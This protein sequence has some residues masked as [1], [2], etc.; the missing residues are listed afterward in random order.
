M[1]MERRLRAQLTASVAA[2][3]FVMLAFIIV[4]STFL[5]RQQLDA[6]ADAVLDIVLDYDGSV[7]SGYV[8][9]PSTGSASINDI[10]GAQFFVASIDPSGSVTGVNLDGIGLLDGDTALRLAQE[11][12]RRAGPDSG[13]IEGYRY[14][15]RHGSDG[16]MTVAFL[17]RTSQSDT[18]RYSTLAIS[19][20]SLAVM[21]GTT[22]VFA[23]LS[24]RIVAPIVRS[25]V[26]QRQFVVD[27]G[28]DLRTPVSIISADADILA[29]DIGEDNEWLLDIKRQVAVMSELT[30]SLIVLSRA[31]A[32]IA[33]DDVVDIGELVGEQVSSFRSRALLEGHELELGR[34][35]GVW[36]RGNRQY[37]ARMVGSLLDNALKYSSVGAAI[38]VRVERHVRQ[39][40]VS[41]SNAVDDADPADVRRWFDRFYQSDRSRDHHVG[42]FGIGLAMVRAVAEAHGGRA[43][44]SVSSDHRRV[45]MTV[46]MPL[47]VR[48]GNRP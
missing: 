30:E 36:V 34:M 5:R 4:S 10:L 2:A 25:Q 46:S 24:R 3:L 22:L 6:T 9:L 37:L 40:E 11:V 41:V 1:E 23:L 16:S 47:P 8:S 44:A 21:V 17:D 15:I 26:A 18:L 42:G 38:S 39:V 33:R 19:W 13:S 14:R 20:I 7:P 32:A 12:Y 29:M 48:K 45:T 27:A 28:H 43:R 31:S 35:D